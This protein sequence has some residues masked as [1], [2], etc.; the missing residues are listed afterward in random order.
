MDY[1]KP[2][3]IDANFEGRND[4]YMEYMSKAD[5]YENLSPKEYLNVIRLHLRIMILIKQNGKFN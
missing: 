3:R 4:N 1:Y 2:I 5:I